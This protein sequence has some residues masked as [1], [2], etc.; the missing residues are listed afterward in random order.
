MCRRARSRATWT[1]ATRSASPSPA[2][3]FRVPLGVLRVVETGV[4]TMESVLESHRARASCWNDRSCQSGWKRTGVTRERRKRKSRPCTSA[5]RASQV[6]L[7]RGAGQ[8][9]FRRWGFVDDAVF[10]SRLGRFGLVNVAR[11]L[12]SDEARSRARLC[13]AQRDRSCFESARARAQYSCRERASQRFR[14]NSLLS[15]PPPKS[16]RTRARAGCLFSRVAK[17]RKKKRHT[18]WSEF[19][20]CVCRL[21]VSDIMTPRPD[22]I[23][24][25]RTVLDALHKMHDGASAS[26]L[27]T[28]TAFLSA[29]LFGSFVSRAFT[30]SVGVCAMNDFW[31][32]A[33]AD[34][35][36]ET[37]RADTDARASFEN[38]P[39]AGKF[40]NLPI[41]D[42]ASG[43]AVG[44]LSLRPLLPE[45]ASERAVVCRLG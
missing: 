23:T 19:E 35:F 36:G 20:R 14:S 39:N 8:R 32:V 18:A 15:S 30:R 45:R 4:R 13:V 40:A 29:R 27:Q 38:D 10:L 22:V 41:V 21:L 37:S 17:K 7:S 24:S 6:L 11:C 3:R 5:R 16:P 12:S 34:T 2:P 33:L 42:P 43:L 25:D 28:P 44:A 26:R 31:C 9:T 1:S